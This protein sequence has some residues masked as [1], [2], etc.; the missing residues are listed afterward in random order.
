MLAKLRH[1]ISTSDNKK[2][3]SNFIALSILQGA[4]FLLPLIT[5]PYLVR[6]LGVD[7][8]G[9]IMFAQAF[10]VYFSMLADYGFNLSGIREISTHRNNHSRVTQIF[11]SIMT[12]KIFLIL[13]GFI[14]M[15]IVVFSFEKFSAHWEL[16]YLT[17]GMVLGTALFPTWFFQGTEKMRYITVLS[18][19]AKT[20]FALS[21]FI[22]VQTPQ[23]Y[24]Y[25]PFLNA[26]GYI[27]VGL[28]SLYV[29]RKD[30]GIQFKFARMPHVKI[31][32]LRGWHIFLSKI[33]INIYTATNT[34][35][36]GLFTNETTVGYYAI[37][38]KVVRIIT[39]LFAPFYQAIYPHVIQL[40]KIS[41]EQT[42]VF[43]QKTLKG[44][45]ILS[46]IVWLGTFIFAESLFNLVFGVNM[47]KSIILFK[48]LS[49]L[50]IILPIAF[51]TFNVN[52]LAYKLDRYFSK[53]YFLGGVL[54]ITLLCLFFTFVASKSIGVSISLLISELVITITAF[55]IFKKHCLKI[56][57]YNKG[58]I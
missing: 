21:I 35:V 26:I 38:E 2:I 31:Q 10:I 22:F 3:T 36:L 15:N 14:T 54:N 58:V 7:K 39:S 1:K 23:D 55:F 40:V 20:I 12:A 50:I 27:F 48:V 28:I 11:S 9:L 18:L 57:I 4:N 6:T 53:I 29:I 41:Q 52:F 45:I 34:F 30:F 37:A 33:S 16:Y 13:F 49:P 51:L 5:F 46:T 8:F 47:S 19:V 42:Q 44:T 43:L 17:Y 25:V 32:F 24:L 56:N